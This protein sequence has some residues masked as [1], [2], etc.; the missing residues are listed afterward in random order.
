MK[1]SYGIYGTS[2]L[3]IK[4]E[5]EQMIREIHAK[6]YPPTPDGYIQCIYN[7]EEYMI[8]ARVKNEQT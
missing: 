2:Y 8:V 6:L 1:I 4:P 5:L 3:N 7:P